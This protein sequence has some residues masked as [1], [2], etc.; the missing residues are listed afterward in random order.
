LRIDLFRMERTQCLYEH[1]VEFN[2]SESGVLPLTVKEILRGTE[3]EFLSLG[4][5]YPES[6]GSTELRENIAQ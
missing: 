1:A 2:L 3:A 4:L 6:D 5:K